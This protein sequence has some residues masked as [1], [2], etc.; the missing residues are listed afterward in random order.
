L[1][2]YPVAARALKATGLLG[3]VPSVTRNVGVSRETPYFSGLFM[4]RAAGIESARA[5]PWLVEVGQK[6][7]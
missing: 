6:N 2:A 5:G 3:E 1:S 7:P 4:E